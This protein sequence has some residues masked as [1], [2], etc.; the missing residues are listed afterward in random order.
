MSKLKIRLDFERMHN[1]RIRSNN[2]KIWR[3]LYPEIKTGSDVKKLYDNLMDSTYLSAREYENMFNNYIIYYLDS[4]SNEFDPIHSTSRLKFHV[5]I[6]YENCG[7]S[8]THR[9]CI[10]NIYI[11]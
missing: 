6:N 10:N 8:Y 11:D 7:F 4:K 2:M 3:S 9:P 1:I 5:S